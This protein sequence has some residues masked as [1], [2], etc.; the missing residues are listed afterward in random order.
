MN[1]LPELA[2]LLL[3]IPI[4]MF[5][6]ECLLGFFSSPRNLAKIDLSQK[7]AAILI[8]AHNEEAVIR[9]TLDG[10]KAQLGAH[11]T[12]VVVADNCN[13]ATASIVREY[14]FTALERVDA[15]Q[16]GKGYAL[17]YGIQ[18]LKQEESP[19]DIVI[20]IDADCHLSEDAIIA[21]KRQ[22]AATGRPVQA[23]YL[24]R[25]GDVTRISVKIA[26]FAFLIK[27]KIRLRGLHRLGMPVPLTGTGMAFPFETLTQANLATG[28]IVEDMRLGVELAERDLGAGYCDESLIYSY[29]PK[30][31][32]AERTQ[33]ER[34]E[35]GHLN[36]LNQFTPRLLKRAIRG[37]SLGALGMALDLLIPPLSLLVMIVF[38]ALGFSML[39][40]LTSG[41][42]E[43][44]HVSLR[45]LLLIGVSVA[46]IWARYGRDILSGDELLHIPAYIASKIAVYIRYARRRQTR[47][48]RTD[49]H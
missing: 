36:I 23:C 49:R 29:F 2:L 6:I 9:S 12:V 33:R 30:S 27:N 15:E 31:E 17:D 44:F 41:H 7:R 26:E 21:L 38:G 39:W 10:L 32:A 28:D 16:H 20:I 22:V 5:C 43:Y 45:Y 34:W 18:H 46:L 3:G 35:H 14:G 4:V 11:D 42:W 19:P 37:P 47:W 24:M 1:F 25:S 8:P 40:G 13:D 48:I